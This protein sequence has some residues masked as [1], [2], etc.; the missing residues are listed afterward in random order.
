MTAE[1]FGLA[2]GTAGEK[3]HKQPVWGKLLGLYLCVYERFEMGT[4]VPV[5]PTYI[6]ASRHLCSLLK[7]LGGL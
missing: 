3:P 1:K 2:F 4:N 6:V 7:Q 5:C